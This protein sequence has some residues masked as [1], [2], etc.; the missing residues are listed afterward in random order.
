MSGRIPKDRPGYTGYVCDGL[1]PYI[2]QCPCCKDEEHQ[3]CEEEY[4]NIPVDT[5]ISTKSAAWVSDAGTYI[6]KGPSVPGTNRH[7]W[8][9]TPPSPTF[10]PLE[11]CDVI[12]S[13]YNFLVTDYIDVPP[14]RTR[15]LSIAPSQD[16]LDIEKLCHMCYNV[17]YEE[18]SGI[19]PKFYYEDADDVHVD[20]YYDGVVGAYPPMKYK[21]SEV[22][23]HYTEGSDCTH[24]VFSVCGWLDS[25]VDPDC[26]S[27]KYIKF[28]KEGRIIKFDYKSISGY[29]SSGTVVLTSKDGCLEWLATTE[30]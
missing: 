29:Q 9:V 15:G 16:T 21:K 1:D 27:D 14:I 28:D 8:E 10:N 4:L 11:C 26:P 17:D 13:S 23:G 20:A 7:I 2:L 18:G 25:Y 6:T 3:E 30:C 22:A 5:G 12:D 24:V 19:P